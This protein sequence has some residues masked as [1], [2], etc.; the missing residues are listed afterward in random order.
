MVQPLFSYGGVL[1]MIRGG[2]TG[3]PSME[4]FRAFDWGSGPVGLWMD[5]LQAFTVFNDTSVTISHNSH[6]I[7]AIGLVGGAHIIVDMKSEKG[8]LFTFD[9]KGNPTGGHI[10]SL[11]VT[12]D[13]SPAYKITGMSAKITTVMDDIKDSPYQPTTV[14]KD[15]LGTGKVNII[16]SDHNDILDGQKAQATFVYKSEP[17][18]NDTVE[19]RSGDK[20]EFAKTI[21]NNFH[22]VMSHA[23]VEFGDVVITLDATNS[24]TLGTVH[25]LSHLTAGDFLFV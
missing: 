9:K 15:L 4:I 22:D 5:N 18:G 3:D 16:G 7:R 1:F 25:H 2:I 12:A 23:S 24:I 10:G 13:G 8:H 21:L 6:E 17:F 11:E 20:I 14:L 19:F